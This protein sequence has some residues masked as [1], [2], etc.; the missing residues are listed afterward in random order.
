MGDQ[1]NQKK[2][3]I[4]NMMRMMIDFLWDKCFTD[5]FIHFIQA[6]VC[7]GLSSSLCG[8]AA[9]LESAEDKT[10]CKGFVLFFLRITLQ[11]M[12][13]FASRMQGSRF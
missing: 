10:R 3:V 9:Q 8:F 11:L 5:S 13:S 7:S 1:A 4:R 2:H 6:E 12:P